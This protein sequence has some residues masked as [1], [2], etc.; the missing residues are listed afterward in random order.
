VRFVTW[1]SVSALLIDDKPNFAQPYHLSASLPVYIERGKTGREARVGL[2]DTLRLSV[3]FS[4]L[5]E[6]SAVSDARNAL[7]ALNT[8]PVLLPLWVAKRHQGD[9]HPVSA[10]W[11]AVYRDG[12]TTQIYSTGSI[13]SGLGASDWI[14]PIMVGILAEWPDPELMHSEL[15][16]VS[17]VFAENTAQ[18][19]TIDTY[20]APVWISVGG[21]YPTLFPWRPNLSIVPRGSGAR[22]EIDRQHVGKARS[23]ADA[24]YAQPSYRRETRSYTL[25]DNDPWSFLRYWL[26]N[27]TAPVWLR[28]E[29]SESRLSADVASG[30]TS[31]AVD[32]PTAIGSNSFALLDDGTH[33]APLKITGQTL[34]T[35]SLAYGVNGSFSKDSTQILGL[36]L[37]RFDDQ[38]V[39][40]RFEHDTL[41][42]VDLRWREV[43]W[44]TITPAGE[45]P[46][47]TTGSVPTSA[48]L[49]EFSCAIQG[50]TQ[51][52]RFTDFE[53]PL[54]YG[55]NTYD[56]QPFEHG[57]I[58][59][60]LGLE[61][62]R[63]TIKSRTFTGNPL[64]LLVPFQLETPLMVE[65]T[66]VDVSGSTASNP[67][68]V[69]YGEVSGA[70]LSGPFI[71]AEAESLPSLFERKVPRLLMQPTCNWALFDAGCGLNKSAFEYLAKVGS[72]T[73]SGLALVV[74][75]IT[76]ASV[77][78]VGLAAHLFAG[79]YAIIGT[80]AAQQF[81]LI[82]DNA[83]QS[84]SNLT[85]T[86]GTP[87]W[88]TIAAGVD[89]K[90]YPG[91]DGR[92][93]TC[94][95]KF[96]NKA[97]FGGFPFT[98]IGNPSFIRVAK[99]QSSG[100]KK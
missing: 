96:A 23:T 80:G 66:E 88:G 21:V 42:H 81:R 82:G 44:E 19:L 27:A 34:S 28:G 45:T 4:C 31:I 89:V 6:S 41:A 87:L 11:W 50:A 73:T 16:N 40:M 69:F 92:Y 38:S 59:E 13:P 30:Q 58:I 1:N 33:Q 98:P 35:W 86:L 56:Q 70:R 76:L 3:S 74:N 18:T 39:S 62:Q 100:G 51:S 2:G 91:C 53:R 71:D 29:L 14:V 25:Q 68:T 36:M 12:Q 90:L 32:S 95:T 22:V 17:F 79:G 94:N 57:D 60:R 65:I 97:R 37:S 46:G 83:A 24:F 63:I 43:P 72:W 7:Q 49:Y 67:R 8:Q 64:L 26:D 52:Y 84:G 54:T 5:L 55:G 48:Y 78:Q 47:I 10:D 75:N 9:S 77:A 85:L 15:V 93:D 99:S 20:Q 61:R